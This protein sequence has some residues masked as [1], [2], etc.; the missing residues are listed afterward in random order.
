MRQLRFTIPL[1]AL[2]ILPCC[3]D[4]KADFDTVQKI[5]DTSELTIQ[6]TADYSIK[7]KACDDAIN[8]LQSFLAK[9]TEGEWANTARTAID[10]WRSRKS[11]LQQEFASLSQKL[12][13]LTHDQ[14]VQLAVKHH[15]A[16]KIEKIELSDWKS[17]TD[18][19]KIVVNDVYSVKMRG[20]IVGIHVFN[21]K[22]NVSGHIS[23]DT[24]EVAVDNSAIDE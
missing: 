3:S 6:R 15:P 8:A 19:L 1:L 21:F 23:T 9:H 24:K 2:L 4:P 7:A 12:F 11:S 17:T 5:Q 13:Q 16:S 14:A 22:V 10:S 18:G 20:Q